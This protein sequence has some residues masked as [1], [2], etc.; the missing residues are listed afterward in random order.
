MPFRVSPWRCVSKLHSLSAGPGSAAGAVALNILV[1]SQGSIV[2]LHVD[3]LPKPHGLTPHLVHIQNEKLVHSL[4]YLLVQLQP[5]RSQSRICVFQVLAG[6]VQTPPLPAKQSQKPS[7][8]LPG[9]RRD[10][11]WHRKEAPSDSTGWSPNTDHIRADF[12]VVPL[13]LGNGVL[14][15]VVVPVDQLVGCVSLIPPKWLQA[16]S[17]SHNAHQIR[18]IKTLCHLVL[19]A[20]TTEETQ[21]QYDKRSIELSPLQGDDEV[22]GLCVDTY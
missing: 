13:N 12:C 8:G 7:Q 14:K 11:G 18:P 3:A 6:C 17:Q 9:N 15:P 19:V 21:Y 5:R 10:F 22:R 1:K 16:H 2:F 4:G 20:P